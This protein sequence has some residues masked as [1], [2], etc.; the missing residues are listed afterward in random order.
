MW[1]KLSFFPDRHSLLAVVAS[2]GNVYFKASEVGKFLGYSSH[3]T[4]AKRHATRNLRKMIPCKFTY[5]RGG[6]AATDVNT[7]MVFDFEEMIS[8]I[9]KTF[10][11]HEIPCDEKRI[12]E[13]KKLW[14]LG[15]VSTEK[16]DADN[17]RQQIHLPD[18]KSH[19]S[20]T[21]PFPLE[22]RLDRPD[23]VNVQEWIG[24]FSDRVL[25]MF[26]EANDFLLRREDGVSVSVG[27]KEIRQ[28]DGGYASSPKSNEPVNDLY[29]T[30]PPSLNIDYYSSPPPSCNSYRQ[31]E[32]EPQPQH[33]KS[34]YPVFGLEYDGFENNL[35]EEIHVVVRGKKHVFLQLRN[36]RQN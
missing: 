26:E 27:G 18:P 11:N 5:G 16:H 17:F 7:T 22:V 3:Y 15:T 12:D 31:Q 8:T 1:L 20:H 10:K 35:P 14:Q 34:V 6:R 28:R 21:A 24:E 36:A 33:F 9:R 23:G 29:D 13:L 2:D 4:F 32:N 25:K 19:M 30:P